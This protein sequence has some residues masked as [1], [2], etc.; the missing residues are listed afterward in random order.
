[1]T[2]WNTDVVTRVGLALFCGGV[3]YLL[4]QTVFKEPIDEAERDA[5]RRVAKGYRNPRR[6]RDASLRISFLSLSLFLGVPIAFAYL[7]LQLRLALLSY[8][9][10]V[11][12]TAVLYVLACDPLPPCVGKLEQ[13]VRRL[14]PMR[15]AASAPSAE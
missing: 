14:V 1:M 10:I 7:R 4:T 2:F 12:T 11:L 6:V 9:L 13:W 3:L 5:F 15:A 8:S